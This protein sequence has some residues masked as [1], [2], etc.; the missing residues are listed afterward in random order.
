MK[1]D[2]VSGLIPAA[3]GQAASAQPA[4]QQADDKL[5]KAAVDF[6]ALLIGQ[7]LKLAAVSEK[8]GM[9][10]A[11]EDEAGAC[12]LQI[13]LEGLAQAASASGGLGLSKMILQGVAQPDSQPP[14][15]SRAGEDL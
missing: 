15:A 7:L 14:A 6:E 9:L 2:S 3:A 8:G 5:R 11:G 1:L 4:K 10:G 12:A 13:A